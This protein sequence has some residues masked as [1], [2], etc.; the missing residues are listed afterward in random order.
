MF[1]IFK[2]SSLIGFFKY[3]K[4]NRV[5]IG[6]FDMTKHFNTKKLDKSSLK[7]RKIS[8]TYKGRKY[9]IARG[10][11]MGWDADEGL[12]KQLFAQYFI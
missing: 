11:I 4:D 5:V 2:E 3:S 9:L 6:S 1:I 7:K 8:I 12:L 10:D